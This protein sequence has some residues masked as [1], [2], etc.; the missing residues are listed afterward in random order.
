[1]KRALAALIACLIMAGMLWTGLRRPVAPGTE[2]S[3]SQPRTDRLRAQVGPDRTGA[4][5]RIESLLDAA[6]KGDLAAYLDS[7]EGALRARLERQADERGRAAF[8][9]DLRKAAGSRKSHAI[10]AAQPDGDGTGFVSVVVEST[11]ADRIERQAYR[12]VRGETDWRI[13]DIEIAR[14]RLPEKPLGSLATYQEPEGVPVEGDPSSRLR[15]VDT[16]SD[17]N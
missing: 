9:Q 1:M 14:E 17:A 11:F 2:S 3:A 12:L 4:S 15:S 6:R 13:V 10:F 8:A 16:D 7:F 5:L